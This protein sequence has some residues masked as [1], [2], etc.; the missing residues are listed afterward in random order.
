V[1]GARGQQWRRRRRR[2]RGARRAATRRGTGAI[3]DGEGRV[4]DHDEAVAPPGRRVSFI[5]IFIVIFIVLCAPD[6]GNGPHRPGICADPAGMF[7]F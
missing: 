7:G 2:G 6:S 5:V 4:E 3:V 1:D